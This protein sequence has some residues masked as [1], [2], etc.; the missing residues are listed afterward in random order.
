MFAGAGSGDTAAGGD[1]EQGAVHLAVDV[2]AVAVQK[3]VGQ[4][5]ELEPGMGAAVA[6]DHHAGGGPHGKQPHIV[7]R[8]QRARTVRGNVIDAAQKNDADSSD[9]A[10]QRFDALL[11]GGVGHEQA[12]CVLLPAARDAQRREGVRQLVWN[13]GLGLGT[14][15]L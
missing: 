8:V 14:E 3:A 6:I 12:G 15:A 2:A 13:M 1:V 9:A 7:P 11:Q 10:P 4:P 5:V